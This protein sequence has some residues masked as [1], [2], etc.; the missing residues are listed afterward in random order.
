MFTDGNPNMF[1]RMASS[2]SVG[3]LAELFVPRRR[4]VCP[5]S[6]P[7]QPGVVFCPFFVNQRETTKPDPSDRYDDDDGENRLNL[8]LLLSDNF[9]AE[10]QSEEL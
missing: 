6:S 2:R 5:F 4:R 10:K 3:M 1:G 8:R 9:K 7:V